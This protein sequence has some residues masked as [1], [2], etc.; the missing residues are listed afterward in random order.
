MSERLFARLPLWGVDLVLMAA[1]GLFFGL[2]GPFGTNDAPVSLRLPYWLTVMMLGGVVI[3]RTEDAL[4][5]IGAVRRLGAFGEWALLTFVATIPQTIVVSASE[6]FYYHGPDDGD[7]FITFLGGLYYL[8]IPVLIVVAAMVP[9][10]RPARRALT[11][12]PTSE[13]GAT[14]RAAETEEAAPS[15][16][17]SD[18]LRKLPAELRGEEIIALQAE[19]HYV[20]VH[21]G[22]G[23]ALILMRLSDAIAAM[24]M[25]AGLRLHRSWW[26]ARN[27]IVKARY[28]RGSGEAELTGGIAAPIS[29]TYAPALR[30][31]GLL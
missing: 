18:F 28:A 4:A 29:R 23:S 12:A 13:P 15:G 1:V 14:E 2:I 19:G 9:L 26:A 3:G 16:P 25:G 20:R 8:F 6:R 27:C 21:A 31:A 22:T 17:S 7:P 5:R 24:P 30:E 11:G 10:L